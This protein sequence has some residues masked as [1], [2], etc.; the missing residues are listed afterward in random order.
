[1]GICLSIAI[2]LY[3]ILATL[4]KVFTGNIVYYFILLF[5]VGQL[6]QGLQLLEQVD[7]ISSDMDLWSTSYLIAEDSEL[8][9]LLT[10]LLGYEATPSVM[11]LLV[12]LNAIIVPILVVKFIDTKQKTNAH[13]IKGGH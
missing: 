10:I 4:T 5:G 9:Y 3:F 13:V 1:M 12:Y 2:L 11:E 7:I 8:G 6:M